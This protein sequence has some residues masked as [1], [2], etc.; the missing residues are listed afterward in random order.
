MKRFQGLNHR[1]VYTQSSVQKINGID[2]IDEVVSTQSPVQK[3]NGMDRIDRVVFIN[4]E[5]RTDRLAEMQEQFNTR[6]MYTKAKRIEA[7]YVPENGMRGATITHIK[8]LRQALLDNLE[9]IMVFEDD[10]DLITSRPELDAYIDS[11]L[12]D[13]NADILCVG[14]SCGDHVHYNDMLE[15]GFNIQTASCYVIKR[16]FILTLL[17][18]WVFNK[19]EI[20]TIDE[21]VPELWNKIGATDVHW[22]PLQSTHIFVIPKVRQVFQRK[23][24]SDLLK[25]VTDYKL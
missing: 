9:T 23:S 22:G 25:K 11:F 8:V 16:K 24:Y 2:N 19:D 18:A 6:L 12:D 4:L 13:P 1:G 10:I 15:R 20:F 5:H 21:H 3:I 17:E 14:N 7:V